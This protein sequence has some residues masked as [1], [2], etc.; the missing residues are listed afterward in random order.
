V[1]LK[2][3]SGAAVGL[4][5]VIVLLTQA[6]VGIIHEKRLEKKI[7]SVIHD[8]LSTEPGTSFDNVAHRYND[9]KLEILADITAPKVFS[10]DKVH[11][12]QDRLNAEIGVNT[13]LIVRC[14]LSHNI[15]ATGCSNLVAT[16]SLEGGFLQSKLAP[17]MQVLQMAEQALRE[18]LI[19]R[20]DVFLEYVDLLQ[21]PSGPVILAGV[22]SSRTPIPFE[23]QQFERVIQ[24][25]LDNP[26]LH[27]LMRCN[28][29][30]DVT[31]KGR[32]LYGWSH[33]GMRALD[34]QELQHR[35][36]AEARAAIEAIPDMFAT[37]VDARRFQDD[38]SVRAEVVGD[39]VLTAPEVSRME[40]RISKAL[41]LQVR[42]FVWSR[43]ELM[44]TRDGLSSLQDFTRRS[45]ESAQTAGDRNG[46]SGTPEIGEG[47][48]KRRIP[49]PS[50][51][52]PIEPGPAP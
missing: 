24:E 52:H 25:R 22:Q 32:I 12:I 41:R 8:A 49:P 7:E 21:F 15:S 6:L 11:R 35:M 3:F 50:F 40:Q 51:R 10:P 46:G 1:F 17:G 2:R 13:N 39:R 38:W 29:Q 34:Q 9:G 14:G 18:M 36:E 4:L 37:N 27:L 47:I 48:I 19:D 20:S 33:F 30:L 16:K 23:V 43:A 5:V 45:I 26:R 28:K 44:V 31:A 42:L